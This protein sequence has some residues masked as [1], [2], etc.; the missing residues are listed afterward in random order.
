MNPGETGGSYR[1]FDYGR[2]ADWYVSRRCTEF[3]KVGDKVQGC[4]WAQAGADPPANVKSLVI[5]LRDGA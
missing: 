2:R 5:K 1:R 4:I 3:A